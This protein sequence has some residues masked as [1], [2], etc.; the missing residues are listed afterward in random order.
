MNTRWPNRQE[1]RARREEIR[2]AGGTLAWIRAGSRAELD[3]AELA[4]RRKINGIAV[5]CGLA[6]PYKDLDAPARE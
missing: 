2:A 5:N 6:P 3:D 1:V 4:R